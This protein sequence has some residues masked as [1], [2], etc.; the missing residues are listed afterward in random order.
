MKY[1]QHDSPGMTRAWPLAVSLVA[2]LFAG[3]VGDDAEDPAPTS[4]TIDDRVLATFPDPQPDLV[5]GFEAVAQLL[6]NDT[7][8]PSGAGNWVQGDYVFSSALNEGFFIADISD[9]AQPSL[10]FDCPDDCE[11]PFARKAEVITHPDGRLTLVLATQTNGLHFWDVTDPENPVWASAITDFDPNHNIAVVPG[12]EYVFNNPSRGSGYPNQLVDASDPYDPRILGDYGRYGCHGTT[13]RGTFG[14]PDFRAYC[15]AIQRTEIWDMSGFDPT[16]KD[17]NITLLG[18]VEFAAGNSPVT[19]SPVFTPPSTPVPSPVGIP[20]PARTL[21]H[22][23]LSNAD[24]TILIIGDEH[25]GGGS[26][27]ACLYSDGET[28]TPFG[29]LWFYDISDEKAPKLLS[30][31]SPPTE[32]PRVPGVPQDP[33][34]A[35]PGAVYGIVPNCTA[36]F[37]TIIPGE[38]KLVMAWYTAGVIMVDFTDPTTPKIIAQYKPEGTNVWN[39]RVHNGYVFTGD[40][41]RGLDVVKL[42]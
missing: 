38:E 34:T 27:G 41:T 31:I 17:F 21:H 42:V 22:L 29:A 8:Y 14:D 16:A 7:A 4:T 18:V 11:T 32:T 20:F 30:W 6:R 35:F 19:G 5:T 10:V 36:H 25:N 1:A 40:I 39:A 15:A 37:G 12:T 13:W 3:C 26:P 24:G 2:V 9:P 23:A 33:T 28:S